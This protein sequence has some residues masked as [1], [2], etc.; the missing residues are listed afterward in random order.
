MSPRSSSSQ[1]L[2]AI[3]MVREFEVALLF[4]LPFLIVGI[5]WARYLLRA[6][7]KPEAGMAWYGLPNTPEGWRKQHEERRRRREAGDDW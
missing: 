4:L 5:G 7:F 1:P 2:A 3:S 6:I